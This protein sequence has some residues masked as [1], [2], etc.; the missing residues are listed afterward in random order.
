[1]RSGSVLDILPQNELRGWSRVSIDRT[2]PGCW[3][4]EAQSVARGNG[5]DAC[6]GY[7]V[8]NVNWLTAWLLWLLLHGV[9]VL[10]V[11]E[12]ILLAILL[13]RRVG[14]THL[15]RHT[16]QT[17]NLLVNASPWILHDL[18]LHGTFQGAVVCIVV[19]VRGASSHRLLRG[20]PQVHLT[21]AIQV[22]RSG[23]LD[24]MKLVGV[25]HLRD[26]VGVEEDKT[27]CQGCRTMELIA[28]A[29]LKLL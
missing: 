8:W 10:N 18:V 27:W 7:L 19:G 17:N 3:H 9:L 20:V 13:T 24:R 22:L 15:V 12:L 23:L 1:M 29:S 4:R 16:L 14:A 5:R 6:S 26:T 28:S 21:E 2:H 11:P 25:R